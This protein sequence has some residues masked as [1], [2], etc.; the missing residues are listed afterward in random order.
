MRLIVILEQLMIIGKG[1]MFP[2]LV[3]SLAVSVAHLKGLL[4]LLGTVQLCTRGD[5]AALVQDDI[6]SKFTYI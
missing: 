6:D 4:S 1:Q 5:A 3:A 2:A